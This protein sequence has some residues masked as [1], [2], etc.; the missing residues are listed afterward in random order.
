M[1]K[2]MRRSMSKENRDFTFRLNYFA[3]CGI[4]SRDTYQYITFFICCERK[5]YTMVSITAEEIL[6]NIENRTY[7]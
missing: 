4:T 2:K 5:E 3:L 6:R 1:Y 7:E